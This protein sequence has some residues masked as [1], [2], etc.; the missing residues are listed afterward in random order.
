MNMITL[1]ARSKNVFSFVR[2]NQMGPFRS[3][4]LQPKPLPQP[5][6][7]THDEK[8][9]R[10]NRPLSPHLTIYSPQLTSMLSIS[11]RATG[12]ALGFYLVTFSFVGLVSP[13]FLVSTIERMEHLPNAVLTTVKF[14]LCFPLCYHFFNG[15][16]H[17]LWDSGLF[18]TIK[19][20][21][22][23]GYVMLLL[24]FSSSIGLALN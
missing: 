18:L 2:P 16:R 5:K 7:E 15:I 14:G 6:M 21:Y 8:N 9:M 22:A 3:I 24:T 1:L 13:D 19:E 11:H 4:V 23:T 10:L 12:I 17:L 20:V